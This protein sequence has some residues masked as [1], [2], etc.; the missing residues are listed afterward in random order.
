MATRA[1][2]ILRPDRPVDTLI[3]IGC[4][5]ALGFTVAAIAGWYLGMYG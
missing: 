4:A 3:G 1:R 2:R 5:I